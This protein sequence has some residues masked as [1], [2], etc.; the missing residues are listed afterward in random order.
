MSLTLALTA[1]LLA[2]SLGQAE[3]ASGPDFDRVWSPP[4][5]KLPKTASIA[6]R[7]AK[8]PGAS[9]PHYPVPSRTPRP[10]RPRAKETAATVRLSAATPAAGLKAGAL[11]VWLAPSKG[12]ERSGIGPV[13]ITR[14]GE[15][16]ARAAGV[17][18]P[19]FA[20]RSTAS[21]SA[22]P[23]EH[24][25]AAKFRVS[26]DPAALNAATGGEFA[27]RGRLVRLPACALTTPKLASCQVRTPV[28][29][30]YDKH[31]KRLTA[32][33]TLATVLPAG[34][35]SISG[36]EASQSLL[37]AAEGGPSGGGGSYTATA[38]APSSGWSAGGE[39]GGFTYSYPV[40]VPPSLGGPAPQVTLG[41]DSS[42]VD[43]KTSATNTQA[44]WIGDGWDYN[45]GY[46][47]RV[48]KPCDK[49]GI[50]GSGDQC[51]AGFNAVLS[52]GSHS[53][54][55]VRDKGAGS[56]SAT[57]DAATG[58]WRL[59]NDDGTKVEFG[60]GAQ[61]GVRDGAYA[62]LTDSGGTTYYFGLNHLPGG[63]G[64]DPAANSVSTV[65]VYTPKS[66]DP[67]Y[68]PAKGNGSWCQMWQRL[69]LD[70]A[71]D[72]HGNLTTFRWA[73]ETNYYQ[74]GAVQ[75][76]G[77]GT[78]T[79]Y[80]R[81][82]TLT[83]IAYG[84]RLDAQVAAKGALAPAARITFT[85]AERCETPATGCDPATRT[86]ANKSNWPDVPVDQEC[87]A[88]GA[89]TN[90]APTYFTTKRLASI[91]T[92]VR[93]GNVW[94]DVDT[95][96]LSHS[97]PNPVDSTSQKA[98]WLDSVQRTGK[99]GGSASTPA[100]TFTPAMLPNRVDGT[101]LVPAPPRINRPR[102]QQI[103]NETGAVVNVDYELPGC[104]R[105]NHVMPPAEDDNTM[106]CYPVRWT[107]P[108]SVAGSDPVLDWFNHYRVA[109]LTEN[110]PVTGAPAKITRYAYGP[111]AWHRDDSEFTD[112]KARTWGEFRGFA[113]VTTT[114]GS[115]NDGPRSQ[116]RTTYR[117][118]MQ[119]DIR[120]SGATRDVPQLTDALGRKS[121]DVDWLAG[122][123]LQQETY[124][125]AGGTVVART[126]NSSS[127]EVDTAT[128]PRGGGLPDLVAR[129][130]S[131]TATATRQEKKTDDTWQT[132]STTTTTDPAR[133]NRVVT[134][135][136]QADGL[137]DICT[138]TEY[139][140]G[141]DPQRTQLESER[142]VV[143]GTDACTATAGSGNT[144]ERVRT[145]YDG[146]PYGQAGVPGDPTRTEVI[147]SY[148]ADGTPNF[149]TTRATGYDAYGRTVSVTDPNSKDGQHP[150]GATVTTA[151]SA[152]ATGELPD[153]VTVS[154]PVPGAPATE[155][156][157]TVTVTDPRRGLPLR[158]TD[159]N[160]KT[161]SQTYDALGRLTAVWL[162]G[163]AQDPATPANL[164][165]AYRVSNQAGVPSTITTATLTQDGDTPVYTTAVR[166]IDGFARTR[167]IQE[168]P[169]NPAYK[170]GRL[171]S[172]TVY[173]SQGRTAHTDAPWFNNAS[174]PSETLVTTAESDIPAQTRTEYD[175]RGRAVVSA[176]RSLGVEQNRTTTTYK[177]A[178]RVDVVPPEGSFPTT[179]LVDAR[180]HRTE[181]WQYRTATA[182]GSALDAV[183][184]RYTYTADGKPLTR[185]DAAGNTWSNE[186]DLRGRET[187]HKEP[188]KGVSRQT[189]DAASRLATTT[190][191][192]GTTLSYSYD[193]LGRKTGLYE[194]DMTPEHQLAGW[195]FDTVPDGKGKA[196]SSTRYVGG[197]DGKA[198]TTAVT[199]Y[200]DGYRPLGSKLTVP[201]P[202]VGQQA[203]TTFTYTTA[204]GYDPVTGT[205][206]S[207]T[208]PALG[209][210]PRDDIAYSLND[211]GQMFSY[212]G[213]TTYDVQTEYDA[214]GRVVRSTVN[215]WGKQVVS[216]TDYDQSTG[217]VRSQ[218]VDQQTALKGSLQQTDYTY[219]PSGKIT[220][221][222][223]LPDNTPSLRDR[224][225]FRYDELNRLAE[226]WTDTGGISVPPA[227]EYRTLDQGECANSRPS[228]ATV[229]GPAAY[230]DE[231]GYDLTGNRTSLVRHDPAGDRAADVTVTQAYGTAGE[232]NAPTTAPDT[233]GGTGGPHALLT[234][235]T[236]TGSTVTGTGRYQY[237]AMGNTTRYQDPASG[238]AEVTW[239]SEGKPA[240][241]TTA[242]QIKGIAGKCLD[243]DGT[244]TADGTAL[245][246]AGC[247]SA[248]GQKYLVTGDRLITA[249]KCVTA[250]GTLAGSAVE[251]RGCDGRPGQTWKP[252]SDGTLYNPDSTR[253]LTVPQGA[254]A[255]GTKPVLDD[256]VLAPPSAQQW[257]IPNSTTTYLYDTEGK[258]L[259]R[260]SP[261][262]TVL[263]LGDDQL[264]IDTATGA[265][266]GTRYYP[267]PGGM[268]IVRI[269]AG[270]AK[271][272]FTVQ[273]ADHHG[274]NTLSVDL[275]SGTVSRR[276]QDPFGNP[277][278]P[279]PTAW[280]G[281]RG[282]VGGRLDPG[283]GLT[284][285]GARQYQ[286][287]TGRF[288]SSDPL[289]DSDDPQ[290]WNGYAY[291]DNNPVNG[292]DPSGLFCD[293]CSVDN[294]G[295]AW[296]DHGPGCTNSGCYHE[297][298][299]HTDL[300]GYWTS[301]K[302]YGPYNPC[303]WCKPKPPVD[304]CPY[305]VKKSSG[306]TS[307][308]RG[309]GPWKPRPTPAPAGSKPGPYGDVIPPSNKWTPISHAYTHT[310]DV[311]SS[312]WMSPEKLMSDFQRDPLKFFP[313]PIEGCTSLTEG[314]ECRLKPGESLPLGM[315]V[316][317]NGVVRV[318]TTSTST[319][320]V[321]ISQS[322]FDDPG[323]VITFTTSEK[324]GRLI[325]TQ[326]GESEGSNPLIWAAV[327]AGS[328][329]YT[330]W[331]MGNNLR[332][333][334]EPPV[335]QSQ[336]SWSLTW[337][338]IRGG[339]GY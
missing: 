158:T 72:A 178:D 90:Y 304:P 248:P 18:G 271:G 268:T 239:N 151:Y 262:T 51:W 202:E 276:A 101:D 321:V 335:T 292:S 330:W 120:K 285:L 88:S 106:S 308:D 112:P 237:D 99:A 264:S 41:Y 74:R 336:L 125:E 209:G 32:E 242:A 324:N 172:D 26:F 129:Y 273:S 274:T 326:R 145:Y 17:D 284:L 47:E 6:A 301:G 71:V 269:G 296:I 214:F 40:Q 220:S 317:G 201:S 53:G 161:T 210:L 217:R 235:E 189:W 265:Q 323:S 56:A 181:S 140:T 208:L 188:D 76:G 232:R 153:K 143:S 132:S 234:A 45:P 255:D 312:R 96:T 179:T 196:A 33:V 288:I 206:V 147:D 207:S 228:A 244:G 293:G 306:S 294:P 338:K 245:R 19:L 119:G 130:T 314:A 81:G 142:L 141:G 31:T 78:R 313:F 162:P 325:M 117:Q 249:D 278:G 212:M 233:G 23:A 263:N 275:S 75:S 100:V 149:V 25:T 35:R 43:G 229:G 198:Y 286:P 65:P 195:T 36:T 240:S 222:T 261:G 126:V 298:G 260:H 38:L 39:S 122:Q 339:L 157:D 77:T 266:T 137:P 231:F 159:A 29:L 215:P 277:R 79:A 114:T 173:D 91:A 170:A 24:G 22:A 146:K 243:L 7:A 246:I 250:T 68:D 85:T 291:S 329:D 155:H 139:A 152:A 213:A 279:Q 204:S 49:A 299:S 175:G 236:K 300:N 267:V 9:R 83:E 13:T 221:I 310:E 315:L 156:W 180:G 182:T 186:Y 164:T 223:N 2:P 87:T 44:S 219:D 211:Y 320:F 225:C 80:T 247:G 280:A 57:T 70:Y 11:P 302:V 332:D 55:L 305:C 238:T 256:C 92:Q 316:G 218:F 176:F 309:P 94:Q 111:A 103:R 118:G 16:A 3:A 148:A 331:K 287:S 66:G 42:S 183:I 252:R 177:G 131:T 174:A 307:D 200:D 303:M 333:H 197:R 328:A 144:V 59:K 322:Y 82:T 191:A 327:K 63:D 154:A 124:D 61:N 54:V 52:F 10:P 104:S 12:A 21:R 98:L 58:V 60:S 319:S 272:A 34:A 192:R 184:S 224:Q 128:H 69:S 187:G 259:V 160:L 127:G 8:K 230:W 15:K 28:P 48:Y 123:V 109:S 168:T 1:S 20:L 281:D 190:D 258:L 108:G 5:T 169:K 194:G 150:D 203:G 46:I 193:L 64:S 253:C 89:C 115:G 257:T 138:R 134:S 318:H 290:S 62:K 113:T 30:R 311:G 163:R 93:V 199:G 95:Y 289:L 254:T 50:T 282:F 337:D 165:F 185:T 27:N 86:V 167:Q 136:D 295:S 37:L 135:L 334:V 133:G 67:C 227:S 105:L 251:L 216:T 171:I 297:D 226:A 73:P 116:V 110:D 205:P 14:A 241:V 4:G 84:Q 107:V 121:S 283:T 97:F 270:T 166:L 102:I